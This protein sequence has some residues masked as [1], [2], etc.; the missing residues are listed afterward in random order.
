MRATLDD[1][2]LTRQAGRFVWLELNFDGPM[3]QAF[4]ARRGVAYTPSLYVLDPADERA[5]AT[6]LGGM[7]LPELNQFLDR[8]ERGYRTRSQSPSDVALARG[9][10]LLGRGRFAEAATAYREAFRLAPSDWSER[11]RAVGSLT[12][13]L[14]VGGEAQACAESAALEAPGMPRDAGFASVV[15]AGFASTN[16]GGDA[17]WAVTA[18]KVLEP[19]AAEAVAVSSALRDHRFQLYQQLMHAA[20]ARGDTVTVV[21]WGDRWLDEIESST[22]SSE[23]ERTALDIARVDAAWAVDEPSRVIPALTASERAMPTNY[24]ASLRL[25]QMQSAAKRYDEALASCDRGLA[26]VTGPIGRTWLLET[27]ADALTARGDTTAARGVLE[28]ALEAAQAI[29]SPSN[30]DNNLGRIRRAMAE[31]AGPRR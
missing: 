17:P 26:H 22:P 18:R 23:N 28:Q 21:R 10:A 9:D 29:G 14:W 20:F 1:P 3:N 5:T 27:K 30:R 7:T 2:A 11:R 25:A 15:L 6:H 16:Q 19:L 13:A 12:W 31:V 4:V 24:N 8:G